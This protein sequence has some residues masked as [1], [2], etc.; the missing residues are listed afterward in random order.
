MCLLKRSLQQRSLQQNR[1]EGLEEK[2]VWIQLFRTEA[3]EGNDD[4]FY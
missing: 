2:L 4:N 1:G 3:V